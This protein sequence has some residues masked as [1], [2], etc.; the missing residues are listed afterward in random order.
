MAA[1]AKR[2][3]A[4]ALHSAASAFRYY[5]TGIINSAGC[6]TTLDHAVILIGYGTSNGTPYW[7]VRNSWGASWGE[8]GY[9]RLYR[10][11]ANDA[12][13]CGI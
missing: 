10:G 3:V 12:G 7:I 1:V 8:S 11:T 2:P 5:K 4:V 9:V 6:G 13:M